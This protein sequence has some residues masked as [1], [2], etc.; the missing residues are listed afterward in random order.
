MKKLLYLTPLFLSGCAVTEWIVDNEGVVGAVGDT[1]EGFGAPGAVIGLGLSTVVGLAKWWEHKRNFK[2]LIE[3]G[4]KI[5]SDMT[6]TQKKI[7][8]DGYEEHMPDKI[9]DAVAKFKPGIKKK[10]E[11]I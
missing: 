10:L 1:A 7:L 4:Q 2:G 5:K 8:I 6:P 11:N 9:K 3:T